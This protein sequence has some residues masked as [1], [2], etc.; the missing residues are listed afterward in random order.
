MVKLWTRQAPRVL[1]VLREGKI[2]KVKKA[3]VDEKYQE[4]SWSF[5]IAYGFLI[6]KMQQYIQP[7]EGEESPIWLHGT[8]LATGG[9]PDSTLL[10]L[11]IPEEQCF[12]MD[13][14][15]WTK[16]LNLS[17]IGSDE[18]DEQRFYAELERQC[19]AHP[20]MVFR[21]S[22]YPLLKQ[23]IMKSWDMLLKKPPEELDHMQAAVWHLEPK[24]VTKIW[25][26]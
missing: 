10:E 4:S 25:E 5:Q 7:G 20:S 26:K 22:C 13:G 18:K 23:E 15:I 12:F 21:T 8:A 1:K 3:Y 2:Y 24:W 17:Y 11:D 6:G 14:R 16:V 9:A 19:I